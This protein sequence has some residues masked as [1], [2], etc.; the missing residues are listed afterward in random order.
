MRKALQ[1]NEMAYRVF[2]GY[3]GLGDKTEC[4]QISESCPEIFLD[5]CEIAE[6]FREATKN[7]FDKDDYQTREN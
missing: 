1:L 5:V 3:C 2:S 6:F 4:N 7:A